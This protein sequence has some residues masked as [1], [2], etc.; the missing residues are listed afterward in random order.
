MQRFSMYPLRA[1][2][3]KDLDEQRGVTNLEPPYQRL[4]VWDT[5]KQRRFIDSIVN[6]V[7]IPKLYFREHIAQSGP[8]GQFRYSV[9]DGK[10]R[11]LAIWR[12]MDNDI[13]LPDDF[14]CFNNGD[15]K[16]AGLNYDQLLD[17]YP[18]LRTRF[19]LY[20]V[21]IILVQ[22]DTDELIEHLFGRLNVQVPLTAP[23]FR[24]VLGGPM[25][26][27]IRKI[28]LQP[29]FTQA[30]RVANNRF[31]HYDL[32]AKMLYITHR[33]GFISTKKRDL[34]NFVLSIKAMQETEESG[35]LVELLGAMESRTTDQL[36]EATS[37]FGSN[38]ALLRSVGRITLYFHTF[39]ICAKS[40][41]KMPLEIQMLEQFNIDV[42]RSRQKSQRMSQGAS[43]TLSPAE[44]ELVRFDQEKQSVNDGSALERQYGYLRSYMINRYHVE[45]PEGG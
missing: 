28:G 20:R 14:V 26:L 4:S 36:R 34:D 32:A 40:G 44:H 3:I 43:E 42:T 8:A 9:I 23:E 38:S 22:S 27:L 37:F 11:L 39:R 5:D 18:I 16:A 6:D 21:P 29:F 13:R 30:V 1:N 35:A 17:K 2:R 7:D 15:Y 31:R 41:M 10:Q 33:D 45:L 25:P 19:D 24:N 12:F